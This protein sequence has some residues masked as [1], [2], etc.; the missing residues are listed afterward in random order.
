MVMKWKFKIPNKNG[1]EYGLNPASINKHIAWTKENI[2]SD[3]KSEFSTYTENPQFEVMNLHI[4]AMSKF[5]TE[6]IVNILASD[7]RTRK[8]ELWRM[9]GV[10]TKTGLSTTKICLS[11]NNEMKIHGYP[12]N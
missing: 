9:I 6:D 7:Q 3:S 12:C 5:T 10:D 4:E 1:I 8:V 11:F 2:E